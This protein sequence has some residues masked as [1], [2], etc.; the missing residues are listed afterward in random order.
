MHKAASIMVVAA[1]ATVIAAVSAAVAVQAVQPSIQPSP[2]EK[3]SSQ[4]AKG[5]PD[6]AD[7]ACQKAGYDGYIGGACGFLNT[8]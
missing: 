4:A 8:H 7:H 1:L 3:A 5:H 2:D 6:Q